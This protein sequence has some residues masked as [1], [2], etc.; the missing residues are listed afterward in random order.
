MRMLETVIKKIY[1]S[2]HEFKRKHV[3]L[4]IGKMVAI[5]FAN[6]RDI[7]S[8]PLYR[9]DQIKMSPLIRYCT[10]SYS[11]KMEQP[12]KEQEQL[13]CSLS[14]TH[15]MVSAIQKFLEF[16]LHVPAFNTWARVDGL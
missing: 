6:Q 11:L 16:L 1:I 3:V 8:F 10:L 7:N 2:I 12:K 15:C 9:Y 13:K 5:F 4:L 14:L